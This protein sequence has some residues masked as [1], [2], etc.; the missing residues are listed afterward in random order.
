MFFHI[1]PYVYVCLCVCENIIASPV[2]YESALFWDHKGLILSNQAETMPSNTNTPTFNMFILKH[3]SQEKK[4]KFSSIFYLN[5]SARPALRCNKAKE[6]CW[7]WHLKYIEK[8]LIHHVI[9]LQWNIWDLQCNPSLII[10]I[11][12]HAEKIAKA[13]C[14]M[15]KMLH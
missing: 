13:F 6:G 12:I 11:K 7:E 3:I 14:S 10:V 4:I 5:I 15:Y 8:K 9:R 1:W 2:V